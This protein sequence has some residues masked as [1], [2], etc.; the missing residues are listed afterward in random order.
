M[1]IRIPSDFRRKLNG[2]GEF[3]SQRE[4][5]VVLESSELA[6]KTECKPPLQLSQHSNFMSEVLE[7]GATECLWFVESPRPRALS[8]LQKAFP[9]H[10][11]LN[12]SIAGYFKIDRP[13]ICEF[14][15]TFAVADAE[16]PWQ[17]EQ[18][19]GL[20]GVDDRLP[21]PESGTFLQRPFWSVEHAL[22]NC[23]RLT[24]IFVQAGWFAF[25]AMRPFESLNQ[26]LRHEFPELD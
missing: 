7:R 14:W 8:M 12:G 17:N 4:G 10:H 24:S 18:A 16:A 19:W 15:S 20:A 1:A 13:L 23:N 2:G 22:K 3:S 21:E 26:R 5:F 6:K 9:S 11:I 25:V